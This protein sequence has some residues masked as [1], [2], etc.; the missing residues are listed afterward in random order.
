MKRS[1]YTQEQSI[2]TLKEEGRTSAELCREKGI[3]E[4]SFFNWRKKY[5]GMEVSEAKQLKQLEEENWRRNSSWPS[6]F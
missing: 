4:G 6:R 2:A 3:S 1:R 5:G